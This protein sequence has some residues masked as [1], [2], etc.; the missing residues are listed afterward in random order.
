MRWLALTITL[1]TCALGCRTEDETPETGPT[2]FNVNME[3]I[4]APGALIPSND[5][6]G[7]ILF[8]PGILVVHTPDFAL[9]EPGSPALWDGFEEM[10][11]DGANAI[12][13]ETLLAEDSVLSATSFAAL[14]ASYADA[15]MFP[16]E[17]ATQSIEA[18]SGDRLTV[19]AMFG[20]SNDVFVAATDI[21]LFD[22]DAPQDVDASTMLQL[23]DAGTEVNEEPGLGDTQAPRQTEAGEGADENGNVVE[24][25]G[26][27]TS[28]F[29]YPTPT[30]M[31]SLQITVGE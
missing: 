6:P 10:V 14:D 17:R 29:A 24:I 28:G 20:E 31:L 13:I 7:D 22:G 4:S 3:N 25:D 8:A 9:F 19:A 27:D 2:Q 11:E 18:V 5:E 23:W 12:L 26:T 16:G 30:D 15:P 1:M 21:A